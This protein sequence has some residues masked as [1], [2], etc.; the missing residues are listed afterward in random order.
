[1][2]WRRFSAEF[3]A[4]SDGVAAKALRRYS[5]CESCARLHAAAPGLMASVSQPL[6]NVGGH[7]PEAS[8]HAEYVVEKGFPK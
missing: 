2:L 5:C 7:A 8:W 6:A 3:L 4:G 1:M